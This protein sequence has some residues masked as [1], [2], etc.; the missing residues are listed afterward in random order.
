MS[1]FETV[2]TALIALASNKLRT[3]LT[4]LGVIIG[5]GSVVTLLSI[6]A[7]V[8]EFVTGRVTALG[9]NLLTLSA[10]NRPP[11]TNARLTNNDVFALSDPVSVPG[12]KYVVP[13]VNGNARASVGTNVRQSSV[14]G[15][16]PDLFIVRNMKMDQGDPFTLDDLEQRNRV[17]VLGS[18]IAENLF[19]KNVLAVDANV[20]INGASYKVVGVSEPKGGFGPGG[21]PDDTI[22][23]PLSVAQEKLFLQR[24][25]GMR[26]VNNIIVEVVDAESTNPT[27]TDITDVLRREHRLLPAQSDDFRVQNQAELLSSLDG[28]TTGLS[29]FLGAVGAISLLVGGIG[30]MNIMLVSVTER[31][32]EIGLRKAIGAKQRTI[33]TQFMIEALVVSAI[34]GL[35]GVAF[36]VGLSVGVAPLIASSVG[37]TFSPVINIPTIGIAFSFAALIGLVFG[38]YPAWRASRL[39]PVVALRFE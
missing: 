1:L 32:R 34:A 33:L 28:I 16:T 7:G 30:I 19:G 24:Q 31:T 36:G 14:Q 15:S 8:R 23:I 25:G 37:S 26:S 18:S 38:L 9:S 21:N 11:N 39:Q 3:V 20:I 22:Y 35:I 2:R 27:L 10:D 29:I 13:I 6:G 5:V 17:A 4:M 12:A